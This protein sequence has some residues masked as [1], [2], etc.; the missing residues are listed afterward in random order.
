MLPTYDPG[1]LVL[2]W[3]SGS[4]PV[5]T[6]IVYRIPDGPGAG[7]NVVHRVVEV[8]PD[9]THVT[10][11]DH[12][13]HVDPWRPTDAD[14]KGR[15]ALPVPRGGIVLRAARRDP[16]PLVRVP[17]AARDD[18]RPARRR[19]GVRVGGPGRGPPTP[20]RWRRH[21]PAPPPT[22]PAQQ[23]RA[24]ARNSGDGA[25]CGTGL[26]ADRD[27]RVRGPDRDPH[28]GRPGRVHGAEL[29][30]G[31]PGLLR[32]GPHQRD[33]A[34]VLRDRDGH[35]P[36]RPGRGVGDHAQ[37]LP[38]A[39]QRH[40]RV[41]VVQRDHRVLPAEPVAGQGRRVQLRA[42]RRW[43]VRVGLLRHPHA[44]R[45]RRRDRGRDRHQLGRRPVLRD[46]GRDDA[47]DGLDPV[48]GEH[49]PRDRRAHRQQLLARRR[50]HQRQQRHDDL[51][52]RR[53][54]HLGGARLG[55]QRVRPGHQPRQLEL[56]R[57]DVGGLPARRC[58]RERDR[59]QLRRWAVLRR[60]DGLDAVPDVR[61]V[62]CDHR[63]H[64]PRPDQRRVLARRPADQLLERD[65]HLVRLG[66]LGAQGHGEQRA[67]P[68]RRA[69]QL[70]LLRADQP[71]RRPRGRDGVGHDHQLR[72]RDLL[73]ERH[74]VDDLDPAR[75][76]AGDHRPHHSRADRADV[77]AGRPADELLE[78][79]QRLLHRAHRDLGTAR[80][81]LERADPGR[82]APD[83]RLLH[84]SP[85]GGD[86]GLRE[87]MRTVSPL[88]RSA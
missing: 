7:L 79:H 27:Q 37:H 76:L 40:R 34:G 9:G 81:E 10:R 2:T 22:R 42:R 28:L 44:A 26:D 29:V 46:R 86:R 60:R 73:R 78:R 77:L 58:D 87:V 82:P 13:D 19:L 84:L 54:R 39:L 20:G 71:G 85:T 21:A 17:T 45:P 63:P 68:A 66:H 55:Q 14:V 83:V 35:Q 64:H 50:A 56:L 11:G 65:E 51:L 80:P 75:A 32:A 38:A 57:T 16:A 36:L 12:N 52:R 15:V 41:V 67:D 6:P 1:D 5:G 70:G 62:A 74:G 72:G 33:R 3:R 23:G 4:Y 31:Q 43:V 48:A 30:G 25:G 61:E 53:D 88:A 47:L 8:R 18:L 24:A 69:G 59:H 49:R